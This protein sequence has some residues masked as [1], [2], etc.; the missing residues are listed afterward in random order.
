MSRIDFFLLAAVGIS[1]LAVPSQMASAVPEDPFLAAIPNVEAIIAQFDDVAFGHEHGTPLGALQKWD[2][3]VRLAFF[4]E[5]PTRI[6]PYIGAVEYH[7]PLLAYLTGLQFLPTAR[8]ED[9]TLR[10]GVLPSAEFPALSPHSNSPQV[11]DFLANS[12]C[13]TIDVSSARNLGHIEQGTIVIGSDISPALQQ[14][15]LLEELV[16][17]LGLPNDACHYRPSLFCEDDHVMAMTL[18]DQ[19]LLRILYD[20][21][22]KAGM[23]RE[24]ALP[25]VRSIVGQELTSKRI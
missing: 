22:L 3:P 18:A 16:Q 15:C 7:L 25:L 23:T 17:V 2:G 14:H 20:K 5:P 4:V 21:R 1:G 10:L 19:M 6:D 11:S 12:A 8:F 13:I 24:V 9:A